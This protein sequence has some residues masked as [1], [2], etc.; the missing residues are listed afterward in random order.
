MKIIK[1]GK[2]PTTFIRFCCRNCG[3]IFDCEKGEYTYHSCQRDGDYYE[4][5]CPI[6]GKRV[7]KDLIV[8][9]ENND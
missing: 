8:K 2:I 7:Y 4:T 1:K 3:C 6:C 5:K 9:G